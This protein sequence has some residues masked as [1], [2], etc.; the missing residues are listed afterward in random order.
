MVTDHQRLY[1]VVECSEAAVVEL[2]RGEPPAAEKVEP[3]SAGATWLPSFSQHA[4]GGLGVLRVLRCRSP[5]LGL[6]SLSTE[7]DIMHRFRGYDG[8][9]AEWSCDS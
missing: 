4:F 6:P 5:G 8:V 7:D 1:A 3:V 2:A 9:A